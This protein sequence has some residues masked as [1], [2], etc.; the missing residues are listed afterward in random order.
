MLST[1]TAWS[2]LQA[3]LKWQDLH[4]ECKIAQFYSQIPDDLA[5]LKENVAIM[6]TVFGSTYICEQTF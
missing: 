6:L 3:S 2:C 1:G 5:K 4:E